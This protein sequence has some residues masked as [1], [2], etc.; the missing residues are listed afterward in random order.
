[1]SSDLGN[2]GFQELDH[3]SADEEAA[4][5]RE[6]ATIKLAN[7]AVAVKETFSDIHDIVKDQ[8]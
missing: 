3:A 8:G 4:K 6:A 5:Q 2:H 1:M 7:E